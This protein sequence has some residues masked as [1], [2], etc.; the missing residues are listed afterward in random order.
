[1]FSRF[2]DEKVITIS[3][4][5][6]PRKIL[7]PLNSSTWKYGEENRKIMFN[8][9]HWLYTTYV[10]IYWNTHVLSL[11]VFNLSFTV[12]LFDLGFYFKIWSARDS[13]LLCVNVKL[14][15]HTMGKRSTNGTVWYGT[16]WFLYRAKIGRNV[17]KIVFFLHK[18][19][20]NS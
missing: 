10:H 17:H 3:R 4:T 20:K 13:T 19:R 5:A 8:Y 11:I 6:K 7:V 12:Y 16:G 9:L 14:G 1:M 18:E 15:P 2:C